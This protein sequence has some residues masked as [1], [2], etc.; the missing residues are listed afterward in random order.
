MTVTLGAAA[1][2][3][4]QSEGVG[5]LETVVFTGLDWMA[6]HYHPS[7]KDETLLSKLVIDRIAQLPKFATAT[8]AAQ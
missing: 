8:A 6:C 4:A 7:L 1:A 3:L 2:A 5:D